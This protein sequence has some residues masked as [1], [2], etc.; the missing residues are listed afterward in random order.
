MANQENSAASANLPNSHPNYVD[1]AS[2]LPKTQLTEGP[3]RELI[4]WIKY[5]IA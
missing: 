1:P 2:F 4:E 3:Q 5:I